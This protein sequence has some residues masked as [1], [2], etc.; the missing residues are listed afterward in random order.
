MKINSIN[1]QQNTQA[2]AGKNPAK[3]SKGAQK[4]YSK[5]TSALV[6]KPALVGALAGSSVVAQ[7]IVMSGSE[8]AIGPVMDVGIGEVITKMKCH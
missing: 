4:I 3:I 6:E 7:K 5:V 1:Q 2:F 8:A